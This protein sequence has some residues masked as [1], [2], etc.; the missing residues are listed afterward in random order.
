MHELLCYLLTKNASPELIK[1]F[2]EATAFVHSSSK[3]E[4]ALVAALAETGLTKPLRKLLVVRITHFI[5]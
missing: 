5:I 1:K 4:T 2:I 3:A